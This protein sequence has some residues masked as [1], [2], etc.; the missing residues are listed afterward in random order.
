MSYVSLCSSFIH[1]TNLPFNNTDHLPRVHIYARLE[2]EYSD[3][4]LIHAL[5]VFAIFW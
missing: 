1:Q 2:N 4:D 5:K 3:E